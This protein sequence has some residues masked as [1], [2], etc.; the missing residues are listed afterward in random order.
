MAFGVSELFMARVFSNGDVDGPDL[1][2][3]LFV[4]SAR[5]KAGLRQA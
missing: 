1:V 5:A 3:G 4:K 2:A